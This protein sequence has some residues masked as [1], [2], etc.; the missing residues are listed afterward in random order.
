MNKKTENGKILL[1]IKIIFV[2]TVYSMRYFKE[3]IISPGKSISLK[4]IFSLTYLSPCS[5][6]I[7]FEN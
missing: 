3:S 5:L 4:I 1:K 7:H 6:R 2:P